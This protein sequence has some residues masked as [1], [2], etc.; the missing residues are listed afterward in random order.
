MYL[1]AEV[2]SLYVTNSADPHAVAAFQ[3]T[4]ARLLTEDVATLYMAQL[5]HSAAGAGLGYLTM[6]HDYGVAL[7][8]E[9]GPSLQD[10]DVVTVTTM[11]CLSV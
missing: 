2:V 3:Q 11:A 9:F 5:A 6:L 1:E 8:W 4:I 10:P 7:A